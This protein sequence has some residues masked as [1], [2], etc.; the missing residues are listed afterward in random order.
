MTVA[1]FGS[2]VLGFLQASRNDI[3][4]SST[5]PASYAPGV[6]PRRGFTLVEILIVISIIALLAM[7]LFPAFSR[8]RE[9]ARRTSCASNLKQLSLGMIQYAQD[10]NEFLPPD[11]P[12]YSSLP[13][14]SRPTMFNIPAATRRTTSACNPTAS[15][16]VTWNWSDLIFPY[17]KNSGAYND[18]SDANK[19][20]SN[21]VRPQPTGGTCVDPLAVLGRSRAWVYQGPMVPMINL[22]PSTGTPPVTQSARDGLA[23]GYLYP[24]TYSSDPRPGIALSALAYP[25]EKGLL[26]EASNYSVGDYRVLIT[27]HFDGVNVVFAD[28]HVRW[29]KWAKIE[30]K[31]STT[32]SENGKRF[33]FLNG[34]T[35]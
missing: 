18:P 32:L 5:A 30:D 33:W 35:T 24:Q 13:T 22:A 8:A 11:R 28:G 6:L 23:Y 7:I 31:T 1:I 19:Y 12:F 9:N 15:D 34:E 17:V 10:Y 3:A 2:E 20:F 29:I 26:A 25:S 27:R 21:C 14:N 4:R 16:C